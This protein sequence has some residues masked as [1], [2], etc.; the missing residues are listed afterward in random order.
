MNNIL[1]GLSWPYC[2]GELHI[3]HLGSSLPADVLARYFRLKG[4]KVC[5][6]SG[7]DCFGTPIS[8]QAQKE[9]RS[10]EEI[11]DYY[12]NKFVDIFQRLNFSFD[13]YTQTNNNEHIKF[14]KDFH[15]KLFKTEF[16]EKRSKPATYCENCERF[17]PD[18]FVVGICPK[19]GEKARGDNCDFCGQVLE[20]E[21]LNEPKCLLCGETPERKDNKQYYILLTKLQNHIEAYLNKNKSNWTL[22]AVNLTK[23]YLQEGLQDRA[24]TRNIDWGVDLPFAD[25]ERKIYNWAEN[26]LGYLVACKKWCDGNRI[27]FEEFYN[28]INAR[29]F[30]VHAKDNIP[31][32]TVIFPALLI[33]HG[34]YDTFQNILAYE[35]VTNNGKKI[36]KSLGTVLT[37]VELLK[38][39]ESDVLRFYF[40][41]GVNSTR[42]FN[43]TTKEMLE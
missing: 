18:R 17:L 40:L 34:K 28:D 33:A 39:Y 37:C 4:D 31:F 2:N 12:H 13:V 35:F 38:K 5:F 10:P 6:V 11:T 43:F 19:C 32:H 1:I 27:D 29:R 3:G 9:K 30:L 21:D 20:P 23:R 36:S 42:D 15:A 7:S 24:I 8:I 22:N 41:K 14:C 26:V 25:S 16:V